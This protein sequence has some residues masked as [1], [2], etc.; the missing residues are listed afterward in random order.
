MICWCNVGN[1]C[2]AR[3]VLTGGVWGSGFQSAQNGQLHWDGIDWARA[4]ERKVLSFGKLP[5]T[6]VNKV[7]S[8]A[9]AP[10][11]LIYNFTCFHG[12]N[13]IKAW[14]SST[15]FMEYISSKCL[16]NSEKKYNEENWTNNLVNQNSEWSISATIFHVYC[17]NLSWNKYHESMILINWLHGIYFLKKR[18]QRELN[19][20]PCQPKF[21]T[22]H[23]RHQFLFVLAYAFMEYLTSKHDPYEKQSTGKI[24]TEV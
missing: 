23:E 18:Q 15:D 7:L 9:S 1:I 2:N 22:K 20:Q 6:L 8:E 4:L 21:Y 17:I 19:H 3:K 13:T 16:S 12:I 10:L 5:T 14:S 24:D 11:I